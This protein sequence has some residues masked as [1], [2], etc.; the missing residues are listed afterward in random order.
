MLLGCYIY[1]IA[2]QSDKNNFPAD[3]LSHAYF[4]VAICDKKG[5]E[6]YVHLSPTE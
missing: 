2:Y 6:V 3:V 4:G 5:Q 1:D